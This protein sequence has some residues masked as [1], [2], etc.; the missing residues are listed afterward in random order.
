MWEIV[1]PATIVLTLFAAV[2]FS[3]W[4]IFRQPQANAALDEPMRRAPPEGDL[5]M[6]RPVAAP[7][8]SPAPA[9]HPRQRKHTAVAGATGD[10]KTTTLN[11][12]LVQD[13]AAGAQ[14]VVCSTHFT[15]YHPEDQSV[16]L[17]PLCDFFEVYY[18]P[19]DILKAMV[20]ACA[21]IDA[22]LER[23][24]AGKDVGHDVTLYF[25][26][27]DTAIQRTLGDKATERLLH[28]LDEGRKTRVWV[29]FIEVHGAQVKRFGGDS[30]L[31]AAFTTRLAG[32]IDAS[33]WRTFIG[34]DIPRQPVP[35][36]AWMT[37][38]GL[39]TIQPPSRADIAQVVRTT[40]PRLFA[41]IASSVSE[42]EMSGRVIGFGEKRG[43]A[44]EFPLLG[45][46]AEISKGA[47]TSFQA[48][49]SDF[50]VSDTTFSVEEIAQ[51][52]VLIAV[53]NGK[54]ETIKSMPR[55]SGRRHAAYA[56]LYD[57]LRAACESL[58]TEIAA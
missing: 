20:A 1:L 40:P 33:S 38:T 35:R 11:T 3:L 43:T 10:G 39:I 12:L 53:G 34:D 57:R 7:K 52:A 22:R 19:E 26:E 48:Q 15:Y 8:L 58:D 14:C 25:G 49:E 54:T 45:N 56:A 50:T 32:N 31:R 27:W 6:R 18:T 9:F 24:R 51:I 30:A 13:I 29:G 41:P 55:Y 28:I 46:G 47:E 23:Y 42:E 37:P 17:R 21:L 5:E 4:A 16:D 44:H 2:F 36:G